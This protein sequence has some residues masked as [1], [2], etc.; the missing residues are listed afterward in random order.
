MNDI[1]INDPKTLLF[2]YIIS[3]LLFKE[4]NSNLINKLFVLIICIIYL[5]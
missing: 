2:K 5:K 3:M 4:F 1:N